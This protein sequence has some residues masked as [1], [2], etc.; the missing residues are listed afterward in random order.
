LKKIKIL[1]ISHINKILNKANYNTLKIVYCPLMT[2]T[3][4]VE[5]CLFIL[6]IAFVQLGK[7]VENNH[8]ITLIVEKLAAL[9]FTQVNK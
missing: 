8:F 2:Y 5:D 9:Q 1:L 3:K 7:L 4:I 6:V